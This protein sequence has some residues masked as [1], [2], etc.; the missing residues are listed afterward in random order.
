MRIVDLVCGIRS[1]VAISATTFAL[2]VV[3]LGVSAV[4]Q[5]AGAQPCVPA[6]SEGFGPPPNLGFNGTVS[7]LIRFDPDGPG[8]SPF[9]LVAGGSFTTAGGVAANNIAMWDGVAWAPLGNGVSG[10][11]SSMVLF[12]GNLIVGG[13]FGNAGLMAAPR[14]AQWDGA[15]WSDL[16]GGLNSDVNSMAV[17][18][19]ELFVGGSF[20]TA[21]A[22][23]SLAGANRIARWD[24]VA[25]AGVAGGANSTVSSMLVFDDDGA[26]PNPLSL[27]VGGSFSSVGAGPA[28]S[29]SRIARW[30]GA[31]WF[32]VA[33]GMNGAVTAMASFDD[34]SGSALFAG[35]DFTT[36]GGFGASRIARWNGV[37]WSALGAGVNSMVSA[38]AVF[39]AGLGGGP[40]LYAGGAF[41]TAG[42]QSANSIARWN[43]VAWSPLGA[44]TNG[45]VNAFAVHD[46]DGGGNALFV[47]GAFTV[48]DQVA[49]SRIAR[50]RSEN[51]SSF[52]RSN[53]VTGGIDRLVT[54]N[55]GNGPALY[56]IGALTNA[57]GLASSRIARWSAGAW[58]G[59][60]G[61]AN[62][63]VS[64]LTIYD[65][66]SGRAL[67]ASGSF[68]RI[69][70]VDANFIARWNGSVWS[71]L[72]TGTNIP[73]TAMAVF[74]EDGAGPNPPGLYAACDFFVAGG[75]PVNRIA[76]WNG[77]LWT[78]LGELGGGLAAGKVSALAVYDDGS[79]P[80]LY[81]GGEF[82][83]VNDLPISFL[84]RWNGVAWSAVGTGLNGAV[85]AL[86]VLDPGAGPALFVRG[87]FTN[88]GGAP[89]NRIA[90]WNG[91]WDGLGG[92]VAGSASVLDL[93]VFDE[94][95]GP[96][97]FAAGDFTSIGGLSA[98]RIARWD[99]IAWSPLGAFGLSGT[100]RALT[101]FDDGS[102]PDLYVGG[103]FTE[104]GGLS[105][106]RIAQWSGTKW[107]VLGL[108]VNNV[109]AQAVSVRD[110]AVFN[111]GA[112]AALFV[113]GS[114]EQAGPFAGSNFARW[115]GCSACNGDANG[116]NMVNFADITAVLSNWQTNGANGGDANGDGVVNFADITT[117]LSNWQQPCP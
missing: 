18:N 27:F 49:A 12:N 22:G 38:L 76:R 43:G 66:G 34:G 93:A 80:A 57:G 58:T 59:L 112:G 114:F 111:D 117:V 110:L 25:W 101:V 103:D 63:A 81:V 37:A 21:G 74:D 19:G 60:A 36:A 108:G 29:A 116:D 20:T 54:L 97:L 9:V 95:F 91:A 90:K 2:A 39:D 86:D 6:W 48:A 113:G 15:T 92:G 7:A 11:V 55:D 4:S 68:T 35:G 50:F 96:S 115:N 82:T 78:P 70:G 51:F 26:G 24:G 30:D 16:A 32:P 45:S 104:A 64:D 83:H 69:G 14:I 89:A 106:R 79:G 52:G 28:V 13:S 3:H 41:A 1:V 98:N 46:D 31:L 44:G 8:P 33:A 62:A 5:Q 105:A 61:G 75:L 56:A 47:G 85:S 99:G 17:F 10:P 71:P 40:A 87:L 94:G 42:G 23:V 73:I 88:A 67:Y 100:A 65:D 53:G 102:G 109:S 107:S 84:A 77:A 72:G